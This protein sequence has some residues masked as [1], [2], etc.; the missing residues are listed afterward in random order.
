[1]TTATIARETTDSRKRLKRIVDQ[2]L[3]VLCERSDAANKDPQRQLSGR[4]FFPLHVDPAC[5]QKTALANAVTALA[6]LWKIPASS[7]PKTHDV[8]RS[9]QSL[10]L[11]GHAVSGSSN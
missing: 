7:R 10:R 3:A 2:S 9:R 8:P 1:M 11:A 6:A 4:R 5:I